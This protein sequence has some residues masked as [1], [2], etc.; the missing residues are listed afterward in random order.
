MR[1][2]L[3]GLICIS[4]S[5]LGSAAT[6]RALPE[7]DVPDDRRLSEL[8]TLNSY[9]PFKSMTDPKQWPARQ[10]EIQRRILLSQGLWPMP[11]KSDLNASVHGRVEQDDYVVDRVILESIPGHFLTGSLYRPKSGEGPFPAVLSPHGHWQDGRFYTASDN[12]VRSDLASGA[13]RFENASRYPIQ[14]RAVQLARMGCVV[15]VYDMT[16]NADSIQIGHRPDKASHLDRKS[17]WGFFSTQAELRLQN[18]MGLQT[19]NSIRALDFLLQLD[20]VDPQRVGVTGASGG[21][22]QSMILGAIDD[23]ITAAMPCVMVSTSMQGGCTCENAPYL[24]VDQGNIDIAAAIA[25]RPL[26]L[27]AADDW[28]V[29]LQSKGYPELRQLYAN[30]GHKN[31]LTAAFNVHFKHNYNHVNRTV[32][33]GF[34]NQHFKLGF[35]APVL[36]RDFSPLS[37]AEATVWTADHPAPVGDSIGDVHEVRILQLATAESGRHMEEL[38]LESEDQVGGFH[39]VIGGA[40]ETIINRNLDQVRDV[41]YTKTKEMNLN[42]LT[43]S[44]GILDHAGEQ[45][46][47]AEINGTGEKGTVVWITDEGKQGL[48]D[49]DHVRPF[50]A[51]VAQAG[52]RVVSADLFGQGEF[53]KDG[54]SLDAQR[55]WY[56]RGGDAAWQKFSG[57]TYGYNH[58][59]FV[60]R[61]HDVLSVLKQVSAGTDRNVYLVGMGAQ[62][63]AIAVAARSQSGDAIARTFVDFQGFRFDSLDRQDDPMFVPGA[64]KYLDVDGLLSLCIPAKL[65]VVGVENSIVNRVGQSSGKPGGVQWHN[66]RGDLLSAIRKAIS[67]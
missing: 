30:L 44:L 9:F 14:A 5:I 55:R 49:G 35:D 62:A 1:A 22:T 19:W 28:T 63:G 29:E 4:F 11:T 64:V 13:E 59:L 36:E 7:G 41:R 8:R 3:A 65:D 6:P 32:M 60:Q 52:Y 25:P 24:R 34:F 42:G 33:Y 51:E 12:Q 15:F 66:S 27:T 23:R 50:V 2:S 18:M 39:R 40:W 17:E 38:I 20:D 58:P 67:H 37:R 61:V 53:L 21:G 56:Q 57:Y 46:P 47:M 26:G 48:F 43:A 16:G 54:Q 31:R 10:S 45:L